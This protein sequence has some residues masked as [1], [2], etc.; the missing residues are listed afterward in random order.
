MYGPCPMPFLIKICSA[1]FCIVRYLSNKSQLGLVCTIF[2]LT[3]DI[4][5][6]VLQNVHL[7]NWNL[8]N[9]LLLI[10]KK[11]ELV[12]SAKLH[13]LNLFH[14]NDCLSR[15]AYTYFAQHNIH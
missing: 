5:N 10:H 11:N 15:L 4:G 6:F 3:N 1:D 13:A 2:Q 14:T 7:P 9:A 12:F 8:V